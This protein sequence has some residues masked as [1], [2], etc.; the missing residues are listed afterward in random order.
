MLQNPCVEKGDEA[1]TQAD[2]DALSAPINGIRAANAFLMN[3]KSHTDKAGFDFVAKPVLN[4]HSSI[5]SKKLKFSERTCTNSVPN[6]YK[7]RLPELDEHVRYWICIPLLS[8]L[9]VVCACAWC[10]HSPAV[11]A[12]AHSLRQGGQHVDCRFAG[13]QDSWR[14][15]G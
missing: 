6:M 3:I 7:S 2:R 8:V 13:L 11:H 12:G 5:R 15:F 9:R 10:M 14:A 4:L 1:F